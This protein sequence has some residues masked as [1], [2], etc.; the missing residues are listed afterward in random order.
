MENHCRAEEIAQAV[1]CPLTHR[2]PELGGPEP[3]FKKQGMMAESY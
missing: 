2:G 1:K 3:A